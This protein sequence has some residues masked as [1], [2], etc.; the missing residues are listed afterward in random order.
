MRWFD[1]MVVDAD[2]HHLVD[3]HVAPLALAGAAF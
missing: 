3:V 2:Q 1:H